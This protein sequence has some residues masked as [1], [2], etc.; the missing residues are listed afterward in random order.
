M[1]TGDNINTA[2]AIAKEAGIL[3]SYWTPTGSGEDEVDTTVMEGK[4][5]REYVGGLVTQK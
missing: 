1:V 5:F 4:V 3:P 2:I